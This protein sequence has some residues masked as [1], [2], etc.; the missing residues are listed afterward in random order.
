VSTPTSRSRKPAVL[1]LSL[2]ILLLALV[3]GFGI[4]LPQLDEGGHGGSSDAPLSLPD[5]LPGGYPAADDPA[6]FADTDL[7]EQGEQIADQ[8]RSSTDYGN[9]VLGDVLDRPAAT[10]TYVADGSIPVFVQ[11][12]RADGVAFAPQSFV[13]PASGQ[14]GGTTMERVGAGVCILTYGQSMPG[15]DAAEPMA[16]QCQV[17]GD[18]ITV[19]LHASGVPAADLVASGEELLADLQDQ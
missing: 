12:F 7:A 6:A 8:Q 2:G 16:A 19:Q 10:R 4:G 13:D 9:S 5:E 1:G 15:D 18:G 3:A 14:G 11:V 17:A